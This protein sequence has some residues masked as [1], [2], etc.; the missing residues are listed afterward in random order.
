MFVVGLIFLFILL[1]GSV[2]VSIHMFLFFFVLLFFGVLG[3]VADEQL[4]AA[5]FCKV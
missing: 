5:G 2:W 3:H 1:S 4:R